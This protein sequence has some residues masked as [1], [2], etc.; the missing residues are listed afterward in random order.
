MKNKS[1]KVSKLDINYQ[2]NYFKETKNIVQSSKQ[3]QQ[4]RQFDD[5]KFL[6]FQ[7]NY[8]PFDKQSQQDEYDEYG[9]TKKDIRTWGSKGRQQDKDIYS[10]SE[11]GNEEN[12]EN[13][14]DVENNMNG[15]GDQN[16]IAL[17]DKMN[18]QKDQ[19]SQIDNE[20]MLIQEQKKLTIQIQNNKQKQEDKLISNLMQKIAFYQFKKQQ[21]LDILQK[22]DQDLINFKPLASSEFI[23]EG[24]EAEIQMDIE[25]EF[26]NQRYNTIIFLG[27]ILN[28]YMK[29]INLEY[30]ENLNNI[31]PSNLEQGFENYHISKKDIYP[32]HLSKQEF[33]T[34][35]Y[36]EFSPHYIQKP[37]AFKKNLQ[38]KLSNEYRLNFIKLKFNKGVD[39]K[40]IEKIEEN[41]LI[42]D[43]IPSTIF[44]KVIDLSLSTKN[45]LSILLSANCLASLS[46]FNILN[47][48]GDDSI[49]DQKNKTNYHNYLRLLFDSILQQRALQ[50]LSILNIPL[51]SQSFL[52]S[53]QSI[54]IGQCYINSLQLE[55]N[56]S[57][58]DQQDLL[59][60]IS[61]LPC[62]K[63]FQC[64][65]LI[66]DTLEKIELLNS[67]LKRITSAKIVIVQ[68]PN[69]FNFL[70]EFEN[71]K[72]LEIHIGI[73]KQMLTNRKLENFFKS[74]SKSKNLKQLKFR[75]FLSIKKKQNQKNKEQY[76][77]NENQ[78]DDIEEQQSQNNDDDYDNQNDNEDEEE[79]E[80]EDQSINSNEDEDEYEYDNS[81]NNRYNRQY[82]NGSS[83][84]DDD[85]EEEE[86]EGQLLCEDEINFEKSYQFFNLL[87]DLEDLQDVEFELELSQNLAESLNSFLQQS[88]NLKKFML[89]SNSKFTYNKYYQAFLQEF[90]LLNSSKVDFKNIYEIINSKQSLSNFHLNLKNYQIYYG[91]L[92]EKDENYILNIE[93][94][95]LPLNNTGFNPI[96]FQLPN[97]LEF[98]FK[99][100]NENIDCYEQ[101]NQILL[102]LQKSENLQQ[103][104][105]EIQNK[106]RD[107]DYYY[108]QKKQNNDE[109][110]KRQNFNS[111]TY[112]LFSNLNNLRQLFKVELQI[113]LDEILLNSLSEFIQS[114]KFIKQLYLKGANSY[115]G[116]N[117]V[118][119]KGYSKLIQS[120]SESQSVKLISFGQFLDVYNIT[121][122]QLQQLQDE[123][124]NPLVKL[125]ENKNRNLATIEILQEFKEDDIELILKSLLASTVPITASFNYRITDKLRRSDILTKLYDQCKDK[126]IIKSESS[127]DN[128]W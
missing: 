15:E 74:L 3:K 91:K 87:N 47:I 71:I 98:N 62:I 86:E 10:Q 35:N 100:S 46:N 94:K 43:L 42:L 78:D 36:Y 1:D 80:E 128:Y 114:N 109:E 51:F 101:L 95:S 13:S 99:T 19:D 52:A 55:S 113:D 119:L 106:Y 39:K 126:K 108:G 107:P 96:N 76:Q 44:T 64:Q 127:G 120:L 65:G 34:L 81:N 110:L 102:S 32:F 17:D 84:Y 23:D 117:L 105:I 75:F 53:L 27:N 7:E 93:Q 66:L 24:K 49:K 60:I 37:D 21:I 79:I 50:S 4:L 69:N 5:I 25:S 8:Y 33:Q 118:N 12:L 54:D 122:S 45:L 77:E 83:N 68:L 41:E 58:K 104:T 89:K 124:T 70:F 85:E 6:N 14:E 103:I 121:K 22:N 26:S 92:R 72:F 116:S 31:Q 111:K 38:N 59:K 67:I 90:K 9:R 48:E 40:L 56:I 2:I 11:I 115:W 30:Q 88:K 125:I 57:E 112:K 63:Y 82:Q 73:K 28:S 18:D 29:E 123:F 16:D 97:L 61:C 20:N